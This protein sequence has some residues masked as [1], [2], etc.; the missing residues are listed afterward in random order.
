MSINIYVVV[1]P[2]DV[3]AMSLLQ[4]LLYHDIADKK[5]VLSDEHVM[6]SA[7]CRVSPSVLLHKSFAEFSEM[8]ITSIILHMV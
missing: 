4:L 7:K 2:V 8:L 5:G 3:C 1:H 6:F